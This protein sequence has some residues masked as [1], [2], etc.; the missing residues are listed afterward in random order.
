MLM[1]MERGFS[2]ISS[3]Q[4]CFKLAG[5]ERNGGQDATGS[6]VGRR[7]APAYLPD[8]E[9]QAPGVPQII[10]YYGCPGRELVKLCLGTLI[11]SGWLCG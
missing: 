8:K 5:F 1:Y 10:V 3:F 7:S 11:P 9:P 6:I 4:C 2:R